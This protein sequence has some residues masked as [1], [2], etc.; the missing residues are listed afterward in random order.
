MVALEAFL[1]RIAQ[2]STRYSTKKPSMMLTF[3]HLVSVSS[4]LL[5]STSKPVS[6]Q[7]DSP[8]EKHSLLTFQ[9]SFVSNASRG[10]LYSDT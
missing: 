8:S 7:S 3:I 1:A 6:K 10:Y 5:L 4:P 9:Y 2:Q